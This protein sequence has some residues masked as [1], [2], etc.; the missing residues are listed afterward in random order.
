[1]SK[2]EVIGGGKIDKKTLN[3]V[4]WRNIFGLQLGWNYEKMQ[5]LGYCYILIPVLKI[6][7]GHDQEKLIRALKRHLGFF[8]TAKP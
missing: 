8:N 2:Q 5:G 7:Y 1:M 6:L 3:K 4:Y